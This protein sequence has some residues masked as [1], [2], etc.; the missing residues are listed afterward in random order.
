MPIRDV[1]GNPSVQLVGAAVIPDMTRL[2]PSN[3]PQRGENRPTFPPFGG[4]E[5]GSPPKREL[6]L[7]AAPRDTIEK[8]DLFR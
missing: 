4:I 8:P 6:L 3:S 7:G 2:P 5:G 1:L